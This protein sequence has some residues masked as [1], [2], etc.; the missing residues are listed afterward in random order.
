MT[1]L[2]KPKDQK[3]SKKRKDTKRL[4]AENH[5]L[6]RKISRI[7]YAPMGHCKCYT[8]G[9]DISWKPGSRFDFMQI[10]H[11]FRRRHT[12]VTWNLNAVMPQCVECN[13]VEGGQEDIAKARRKAEL[14]PKQFKV[15]ED[16]HNIPVK[17]FDPEFVLKTNLDLKAKW[18]QVKGMYT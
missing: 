15:L 17:D 13:E 6:F 3:R 18:K 12:L 1:Y 10:G 16:L 5:D 14:G 9:K 4:V 2:H 11:I 7:Y 8:C